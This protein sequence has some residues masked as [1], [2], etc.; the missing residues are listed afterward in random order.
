MRQALVISVPIL[1]V[2]L[3]VNLF[4]PYTFRGEM[5][6]IMDALLWASLIPLNFLIAKHSQKSIFKTDRTLIIIATIIAVFQIFLSVFMAFFMGFGKNTLV[7]TPKAFAINFPFLLAPFLATEISRAC[8]AQ[9]VNRQKPTAVILLIGL[10]YALLTPTIPQYQSLTSALAITEFLIRTLIPTLATSLLATYLAYLGGF[11]AN[12][13]YMAVPAFFTWFSPILPK[14]RWQ[15]QSILTVIAT[16]VGLIALDAAVKPP[17]TAKERRKIRIY[18]VHPT[19]K[20]KSQ[21][22]YWAVTALTAAIAI[23]STTGLLGF[24]PAIIASGSMQ[25]TLNPG[26]IAVVAATPAKA[27]QVGDI[28]QYRTAQNQE[29]IIHRVIY[30]YEAGSVT[31]FITQGDA[32]K[33]PDNPISERQVAGKVIFTIPKLGWVS[34]CIKEFAG[35]TYTFLTVTLPKALTEGAAFILVVGIPITTALTLTA[36][37]YLLL[38]YKQHKRGKNANSVGVS[39]N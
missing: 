34:I 38:T 8:F 24:T 30:K 27:I 39:P 37:T 20:G 19:R 3:L 26:D 11:P 4:V 29:T 25:P 15:T 21:T 12:L 36:Y 18:N 17:P 1:A 31:W 9:T 16:T 2:Y 14:I 6:F 5:I 13:V 10:F 32:N 28:I 23:W 33:A 7:W 22:V 35:N